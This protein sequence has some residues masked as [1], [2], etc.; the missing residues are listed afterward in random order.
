M[1]DLRTR[2]LAIRELGASALFPY[3]AFRLRLSTGLIRRRTPAMAWSDRPFE[4]WIRGEIPADPA[5][6]AAYRAKTVGPRFFF[7]AAA[8]GLP[9][10]SR[11]L[12]PEVL[13]READEISAGRFRLFGGPA[14]DLGF[15]PDWFAFPPPLADRPRLDSDRHWSEIHLDDAGTDVRLLW[16]LSRFGWVFPLARAY[17]WTGEAKYA[18]SCWALIESWRQAN[19]PNCGVHWASAQEVALRLLALTFA[20]RSF[21]PAWSRQPGRLQEVVQLVGFHAARL[22]P[23]LDYARAQANNHLLSESAGLFTAG[24]LFPELRDSARWRKLGRRL[25]EGGF[26]RQVLD[27]G[28][29]VQHSTN[30]QRLALSLGVWLARLAELCGEPLAQDA[31]EA[32]RR[33]TRSLAVQA[34]EDSG[35]TPSFGPD[36]GSDIL[37]LASVD[38]G[39]VRPTAAAGSRLVLGES[40]YRPGPWDE[41][42]AWF[43][44]GHG[45]RTEAPRSDDLPDTGLHFLRGRETRGALRCVHFHERPGH[46]DQ[47][48]VDLWWRGQL[49]TFDPGSYLYNGLPPWQDGL[50]GAVVHNTPVV[51]GEEPMR[52]AGRFLWVDRAQGRLVGRWESDHLQ[53]VRGEHNGYR[54]LGLTLSRTV[55]LVD[56]EGWLVIDQARGTG[57]HRLTV[58]WNLPD[59]AWKWSPGELHLSTPVGEA[60]IGWD[61]A[62]THAGLARGGMWIAGDPVNGAVALW[63]WRSPR[64]SAIEPCLRLVLDVAG[65]C[66][67]RLR[68]RLSPGGDWPKD[69]TQL[70]ADPGMLER[71]LASASPKTGTE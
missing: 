33:L 12:A 69:L 14:L 2:L 37:R 51:D 57:R 5:G 25:L 9:W 30:Y 42:S 36:D 60:C 27:D 7:D 49:L 34:D 32:I 23:T 64:Y 68:T 43:A 18:D 67:L 13:R 39:D 70:W 56:E 19:S 8:E 41:T 1:T 35:Q 22:P 54:R 52:R 47:L 55:A 46:S 21:F 28:G 44:L 38:A 3:V 26:V 11:E 59:T 58:G 20:E 24:V 15:P 48:H 53:A 45:A 17:R 62:D 50:A 29:Y 66:P 63:G 61:Q 40:W 71:R 65:D 4:S 16:E 10:S 6:F 31:L